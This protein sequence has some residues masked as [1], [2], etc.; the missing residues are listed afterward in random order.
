LVMTDILVVGDAQALLRVFEPLH[1][2]VQPFRAYEGFRAV[3]NR[4][5]SRTSA[6]FCLEICRVSKSR[7]S[8][9]H[10]PAPKRTATHIISEW[11]NRVPSRGITG[12]KRPVFPRRARVVGLRGDRTDAEQDRRHGDRNKMSHFVS[13]VHRVRCDLDLSRAGPEP[14]HMRDRLR[15]VLVRNANLAFPINLRAT[16]CP[17]APPARDPRRSSREDL[18]APLKAAP[19]QPATPCPA[20]PRRIE[21]RIIISTRRPICARSLTAGRS[22]GPVGSANAACSPGHEEA[23]SRDPRYQ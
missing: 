14:S 21:Q 19:T 9:G 13:P 18:Q 3:L 2:E 22:S 8:S 23:V 6:C 4:T 15:N 16:R 7:G 5:K 11:T 20:R 12:V 17:R 10:A 1:R